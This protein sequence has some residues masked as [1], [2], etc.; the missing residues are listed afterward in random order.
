M[1][2]G[3]AEVSTAT[4]RPSVLGSDGAA[5]RRR[6]VLESDIYHSFRSSPATVAAA[7]VTAL[8]VLGAVLAPIIA[9]HTPSNR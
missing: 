3:R 4:A 9:P 2:P 6:R 7:V 5:S 1:E 8:A